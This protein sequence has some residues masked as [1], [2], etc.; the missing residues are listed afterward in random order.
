MIQVAPAEEK[1]EDEPAQKKKKKGKK[2]EDSKDELMNGNVAI[3]ED[4]EAEKG[5][6]SEIAWDKIIKKI[7][8]NVR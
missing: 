7:V 5:D 3:K 1:E 4:E 8:K 2:N 6:T